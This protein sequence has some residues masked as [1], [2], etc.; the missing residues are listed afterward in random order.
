VSDQ[1]K[2]AAAVA[3]VALVESGMVLGL[4]HGSTVQFALEALAERIKAGE[5]KDVIGVPSSQKTQ[6]EATRLG[7]PLG[8]LND[9]EE[10]DLAIDGADEV[11]P[12]LNLIKGG[13]G[14]L[15]REKIVAQASRR[16]AIIVDESKLSDRLGTRFPLPV[17]VLPF[18][19]QR[20]RDFIA[21]LGG[22]PV[23]REDASGRPILSDQGNYLLDCKF[24]PMADPARVAAQLADRAGIVE[25]GLF[26][27]I[28]T[29][30]IAAGANGIR[31]LKRD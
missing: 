7:I 15:L 21:E 6:S 8:D 19:W 1:H 22:N 20:Q 4:G 31:H 5:I 9:Y 29:D 10:L 26:I 17:E 14:A 24:G 12:Q 2:Q 11:D 28:T 16:V 18:A 3:A 27:G 13:G 23:R 30:V 25:H